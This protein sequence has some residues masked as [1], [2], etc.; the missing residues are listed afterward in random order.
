MQNVDLIKNEIKTVIDT[1]DKLI[2]EEKFD[3]LVNFYTEDATLVIK[4]GMNA[5]GREQIKSAFIKIASYFDNSIK[6][7][8][9]KMIYL[10][11]GDTVLVLAQTFLEANQTATDNSEFSMKRRAT[12]VFRKIDEKWLCAI[13]NSYGTSLVD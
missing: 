2:H 3:E 4:P 5:N 6:P 12:Y 8:E 13:D 11:A 1:C 9:G 10:V 7:V